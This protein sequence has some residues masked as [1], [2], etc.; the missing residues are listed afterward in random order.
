[1]NGYHKSWEYITNNTMHTFKISLSTI[2]YIPINYFKLSY[3]QVLG[4]V[5]SV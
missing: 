1:M 3:K 5:L 4:S 2:F